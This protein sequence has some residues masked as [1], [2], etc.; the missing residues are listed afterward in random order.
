MRSIQGIDIDML[1]TAMEISDSFEGQWWLDPATG[2]VEMTGEDVDDSLPRWELE[3]HGA[4]PIPPD[5]PQRGYRDMKDFIATLDDEQVRAALMH[6]IEGK[7]PYRRFKDAV[8]QYPKVR[9]DWYAFHQQRMRHHAITWL[10]AEGL[11]DP[12]EARWALTRG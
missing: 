6:A 2:Q 12:A 9:D 11:V 4:V 7:R 10:V 5:D 8:Y 3:E 1:I